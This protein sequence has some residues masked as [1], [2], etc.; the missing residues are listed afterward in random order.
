MASVGLYGVFLF[1]Q[2]R[3]HTHFFMNEDHQDEHDFHGPLGSNLY[4]SIMLVG[5]LLVVILLAKSL[6]FPIDST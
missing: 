4:H 3:S 1:I 6:A 2:T 5:Y